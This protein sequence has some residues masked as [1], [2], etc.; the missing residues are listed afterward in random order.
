[1]NTEL[2]YKRLGRIEAIDVLRGFTLFGIIIVHL[3]EQYYAGMWPQQYAEATTQT[4]PDKI[5]SGLVAFFI[6]GKFYMIFSFL[7]GLSF[8]IQFSKSDS[9]KNFAGQFAW[10]LT[11]LFIIGFF[12]HL[13]YRGD[14]LTIY[15]LLG[16]GLLL[17]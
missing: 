11:T 7:F 12:H 10:R 14:I 8:F 6:I 3:V 16:F 5:T 17:F 4:L 9:E 2:A 13:H 1:M 15:A